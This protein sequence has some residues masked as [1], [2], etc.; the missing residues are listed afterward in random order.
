MLIHAANAETF[1]IT[2]CL[3]SSRELL[4]ASLRSPK[5]MQKEDSL[6]EITGLLMLT[7]PL[8]N[9]SNNPITYV[10][11]LWF[12]TL[13]SL[14]TLF[15]GMLL[16]NVLMELSG[17]S[18]IIRSQASTAMRFQ[19]C[20]YFVSC[21]DVF[22]HTYIQ[23]PW[24]YSFSYTYSNLSHNSISYVSPGSFS[25]QSLLQTLSV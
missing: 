21:T 16:L 9:L 2:P 24:V 6:V 3:L 14:T 19:L 11:S 17:S 13:P 1:N 22:R 12:G 10:S 18:P 15:V 23:R 25:Q 4:Q 5:C 20:L 8:S 7:H